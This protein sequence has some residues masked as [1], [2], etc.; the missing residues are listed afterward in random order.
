MAAHNAYPAY[1]GNSPLPDV[2]SLNRHEPIVDHVHLSDWRLKD[3]PPSDLVG[4]KP[5][6]AALSEE[7][8]SIRM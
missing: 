4:V 2:E 8:K 5:P 7:Q 3:I 6:V 1:S